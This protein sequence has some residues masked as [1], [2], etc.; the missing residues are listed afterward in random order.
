ML[1]NRFHV[2][3]QAIF[4]LLHNNL[5]QFEGGRQTDELVIFF[6]SLQTERRAKERASKGELF[7]FVLSS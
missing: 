4:V 5:R 6:T 2:L 1:V 7:S 3:R